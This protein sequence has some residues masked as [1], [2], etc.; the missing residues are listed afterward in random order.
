MENTYH[1]S[2][3]FGYLLK[4]IHIKIRKGYRY[5]QILQIINGLHLTFHK[6]LFFSSVK[7]FVK[8]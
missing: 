5:S 3:S 2:K 4:E 7:T 8:C 1:T 6:M